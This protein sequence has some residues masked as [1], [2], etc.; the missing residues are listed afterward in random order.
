[1]TGTKLIVGSDH[2]GFP[3]KQIC[4]EHLPS[5]GYHCEDLGTHST[6]SCDYPEFAF[7]VSQRVLEAGAPGL[8]VC[9]SGLGMTMAANRVPGIRAALCTNEYLARMARKHN[10]ANILCLGARVIGVDLALAILEAF[11]AT[12]FEGGRHRQR[13]ELMDSLSVPVREA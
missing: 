7:K 13:V 9:G 11:L 8:L 5:R 4:V 12:P 3:L 10:D 1:M 2:A 6:D